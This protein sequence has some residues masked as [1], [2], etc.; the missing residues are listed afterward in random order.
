METPGA[1]AA[2][3]PVVRRFIVS[4]GGIAKCRQDSSLLR[5]APIQ[6]CMKSRDANVGE[7]SDVMIDVA[8]A[9]QLVSC[10]RSSLRA[11]WSGTILNS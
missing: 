2:S 7:F 10:S 6:P 9:S 11:R 3:R 5:K 1:T 8:I 4:F